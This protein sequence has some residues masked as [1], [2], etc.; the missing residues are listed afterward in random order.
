MANTAELSRRGPLLT[1]WLPGL[2]S[3]LFAGAASSFNYTSRVPF[4]ERLVAKTGPPGFIAMVVIV[5]GGWTLLALLLRRLFSRAEMKVIKA[6]RPAIERADPDSGFDQA[7]ERSVNGY[8]NSL[9][10]RRLQIMQERTSSGNSF[11]RAVSLV[12]GQSGVDATSLQSVYGPLRAL[13]WA[14]PALGFM[15]TAFEMANAVGGLGNALSKQKDFDGLRNLLVNDVV[16]HLAG[17]FDLTLF[18]LGTSVVCFFLLS[19][20]I[21]HEEAVLT[22]ADNA[23]LQALARINADP[24][25]GP[26]VSGL[27]VECQALRQQAQQLGS[28][29]AQVGQNGN[30]ANLA[31]LLRSI[32]S[33]ISQMGST[34]EAVKTNLEQERVLVLSSGV[35]HNGSRRQL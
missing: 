1:F 3:G 5:V 12:G 25:L 23:S 4:V 15:G 32:A 18:A 24:P 31:A 10:R 30:Y 19:L 17:A 22:E 29:L 35:A 28:A 16:P 26:E 21:A 33:G 14:L 34:V 20:V 2:L 11:E 8:R 13:V 7:L 9:L 27:L 6:A